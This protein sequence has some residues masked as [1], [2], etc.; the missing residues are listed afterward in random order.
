M[1][2][3]VI[4]WLVWKS[5]T[6]LITCNPDVSA[7]ILLVFLKILENKLETLL[8]KV[9]VEMGIDIDLAN[10]EDCLWI[11]TQDPKKAIKF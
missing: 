4:W 10:V 1:L 7:C 9:L 11:K 8:L 5:S 6:G 3:F 2:V